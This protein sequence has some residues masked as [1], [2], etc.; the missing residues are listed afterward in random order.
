MAAEIRIIGLG[1]GSFLIALFVL[2][3]IIL[4]LASFVFRN[5]WLNFFGFLALLIVALVLVL[6]P[7]AS[8]SG[9]AT[10]ANSTPIYSTYYIG[11]GL[12]GAAMIAGCLASLVTLGCQTLVKN[13]HATSID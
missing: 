2:I 5:R 3:W 4:A 9:N 8:A 12:M 13:R 11:L 10:P 7:R 1:L 6:S